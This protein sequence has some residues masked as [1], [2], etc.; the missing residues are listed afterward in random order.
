VVTK[1]LQGASGETGN[2][3]IAGFFFLGRGGDRNGESKYRG[4]N[5][6]MADTKS[7]MKGKRETG[8]WLLF[9]PLLVWALLLY[10]GSALALQAIPR[11]DSYVQQS[12]TSTFGDK[13]TLRVG[14]GNK[15]S[16]YP[17]SCVKSDGFTV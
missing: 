8:K 14:D 15:Y 16:S 7:I 1:G 2:K 4:G 17:E 11:D 5:G 10:P 12:S 9:T 6:E 3:K 13:E